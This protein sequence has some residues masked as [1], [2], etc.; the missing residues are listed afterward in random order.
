MIHAMFLSY[1]QPS[2]PPKRTSSVTNFVVPPAKRV[3]TNND[4]PQWQTVM[5]SVREELLQMVCLVET[6]RMRTDRSLCIQRIGVSLSSEY[7]MN[8]IFLVGSLWEHD[9]HV[10]FSTEPLGLLVGS[11]GTSFRHLNERVPS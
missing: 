10:E 5:Q 6:L 8:F 11:Y 9:Q 3:R 7:R 4:V 1:K 2:S